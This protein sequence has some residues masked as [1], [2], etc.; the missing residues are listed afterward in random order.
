MTV[1]HE[2]L[3]NSIRW[4]WRDFMPPLKKNI[5]CSPETVITNIKMPSMWY[6]PL[7]LPCILDMSGPLIL[8]QIIDFGLACQFEPGKKMNTKAGRRSC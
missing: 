6:L 5:K 8:A 2:I 3:A 4:L 7:F 1:N